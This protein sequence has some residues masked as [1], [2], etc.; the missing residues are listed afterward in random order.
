MKKALIHILFVASIQFMQPLQAQVTTRIFDAGI[1]ET[2][3]PAKVDRLTLFKVP[4]PDDFEQIKAESG[5][6]L[7]VEYNNRF[8]LPVKHKLDVLKESGQYSESKGITTY[9]LTVQATGALNISLQFGEFQLSPN[10][11]LTLYTKHELTDAVTARENNTTGSWATR[12]YQGEVLHLLLRVP[13]AELAQTKL[14]ITQFNVGFAKFGNNFFGNPGASA[15]CNIN[16]V[17]PAGAGWDN[18]RNSVAMIVVGGNEACTGSLIMNTCG[19]NTPYFLTANHCLG[20]SVATWVFQFQTWS[21][22]CNSNSGWRE[23][24]QFNGATLRANHAATDFALLELNQVPNAAGI[25]YSGWTRSGTPATSATGLHHPRGDLMKVSN[26]FNPVISVPWFSGASN[27]W[28]AAFDQGIVQHGSSGSPLYDQNHRVIGQLHGNQNNIC[29]GSNNTCW[30]ITQIPSIGEYGRFDVSWTGGGTSSTRL[31]NWLDPGNT[32]ATT[33]NTTPVSSLHPFYSTG[34]NLMSKDDNLDVG[35]ETNNQSLNIWGSNDIWNRRNTVGSPDDHQEPG[36]QTTAQYN[37]MK[38]RVRNIGCQSSPVAN[39]KMYWTMGATGENWQVAWDGSIQFCTVPAGGEVTIPNTGQ[40]Y[41][42]GQGFNVPVLLPNQN[43]VVEGKWK[44]KNPLIDYACM[45]PGMGSEPMICFLGRILS[46]ADPMFNEQFGPIGPNVKDNNNI[47]TRNT[48]LVNMPGTYSLKKP[49]G[50]SVLLQNYLRRTEAFN[51]RFA[52]LSNRDSRFSQ[53]G[54]VTITLSDR[55]WEAWSESGREARG[56]EVTNEEAHQLQVTDLSNAVLLNVVM[57]PGEY[58]NIGA[59]FMLLQPVDSREEFRFGFSQEIA[60]VI[61]P[62]TPYGSDCLFVVI[63]SDEE[64]RQNEKEGFTAPAPAT[65]LATT[66]AAKPLSS[67]SIMPNPADGKA[68]LQFALNS[69]ETVSI[70]LMEMNGNVIQVVADK[71]FYKKGTHQLSF[72][73]ATLKAG[74]YLV[75]VSSAIGKQSTRLIVS[76]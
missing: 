5:G 42:T 13:N 17:C 37:I 27:H 47:V 12:V 71:V 41:I 21:A 74:S 25:Q 22:L 61:M 54:S 73:V 60:N 62:E 28:R 23:D 19:T 14:S 15:T 50:G 55:L 31:S 46:P 4:L 67:L 35:N 33:T 70:A 11:K 76:H 51:V 6:R 48:K 8:A 66:T 58:M 39:A 68:S 32:G 63:V 65:R 38:L 72:S 30:C 52:A 34:F 36:Y 20:G 45:Q 64:A 69:D 24:I 16:V 18:E 59:E 53:V 3:L 9:G 57:N 26:D 75:T 56:M 10:S 29:S 40:T 7:Q 43:F 2:T 1:P 44:P 49:F